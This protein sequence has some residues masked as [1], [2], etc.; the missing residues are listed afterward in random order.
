VIRPA[1][2]P[3]T[4]RLF[5]ALWPDKRLRSA[6]ARHRD[7]WHW[8]A[9]ARR[10]RTDKLHLTLHFIGAV[11]AART[12]GLLSGLAVP[13]DA[14]EVVLDR[15]ALWPQ[16]L[17]VLE[18]QAVPPPLAALHTALG[19]VLRAAGLPVEERPFRPHL[20]LARRAPGARPPAQAAVLR[21]AV[22]HYALVASDLGAGGGY[23]VLARYPA[24]ETG[25]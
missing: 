19:E 2:A 23:R 20:T 21:W 7:A 3:P 12:A 1:H 18:P 22:S 16:G 24:T 25:A 9:D 6:L 8:P 14:F 11:P 17:A 5:L 4:D 15:P 10:V 13:F